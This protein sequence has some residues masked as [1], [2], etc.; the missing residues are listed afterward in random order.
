MLLYRLQNNTDD[1]LDDLQ[2]FFRELCRNTTFR[3]GPVELQLQ[4]VR[5][6]DVERRSFSVLQRAQSLLTGFLTTRAGDRMDPNVGNYA[7]L[8]SSSLQGMFL[9]DEI[10]TKTTS[11]YSALLEHA[12]LQ[13]PIG[14]GR[15][16]IVT[17]GVGEDAS[18]VNVLA[19]KLAIV[20]G[21][22]P[23][24]QV[25]WTYRDGSWDSSMGPAIQAICVRRDRW[26]QN[27]LPLLWYWTR[28]F[29]QENFTIECLN[30]EAPVSH[31][32]IKASQ[33]TAIPIDFNGDEIVT[34]KN[35]FYKYAGFSVR[36]QL[37]LAAAMMQGT[38]PLD[39][40]GVLYIPLLSIRE[41]NRRTTQPS[42]PIEVQWEENPG[43]RSCAFCS[44]IAPG[45]MYCTRCRTVVY[46]NRTCQKKD[47]KTRHKLWCG[48]TRAEVRELL[49][50]RGLL[51][52]DGSLVL[53]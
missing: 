40:E 41:L 13:R 32:M 52:S 35:F 4:P 18:N 29:L 25:H 43:A 31:I 39:E 48:K 46:C 3:N 22:D 37:G 19:T 53:G 8:Q 38:R 34:E 17:T 42:D 47:W 30:N 12:S 11:G 5:E 10:R 6:V 14:N 49:R 51:L 24:A 20:E 16:L 1:P 26:G 15:E 27:L 7:I 21:G 2:I 23:V 33:L 44:K 45:Q 36:R 50:E 28:T 9:M